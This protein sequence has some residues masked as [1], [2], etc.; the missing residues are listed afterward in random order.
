MSN[1]NNGGGFDFNQHTGGGNSESNLVSHDVRLWAYKPSWG[2]TLSIFQP[3]PE[4][5]NGQSMPM[6]H[7]GQADG[8]A[9]TNWIH[10]RSTVVDIG[11]E[12][13]QFLTTYDSTLTEGEKQK[14]SK[15]P[16]TFLYQQVKILVDSDPNGGNIKR[17][18]L[19]RVRNKTILATKPGATAGFMQGVLV[20]HKNKMLD[21]GPK[22]NILWRVSYGYLKTVGE[23]LAAK[24]ADGSFVIPDIFQAG[25]AIA[26][27]EQDAAGAWTLDRNPQGINPQWMFVDPTQAANACLKDPK[28]TAAGYGVSLVYPTTPAAFATQYP[29]EYQPWDKVFQ[30]LSIQEQMNLLCQA[31]DTEILGK[32]FCNSV[33]EDLLPTYVRNEYARGMAQGWNPNQAPAMPG[34]GGQ[35]QQPAQG[36]G[37]QQ[38]FGGGQQ[39]FPSQQPAYGHPGQQ[40]PQQPVYPGHAQAGQSFPGQMQAPQAPAGPQH[41]GYMPAPAM[42]GAPAHQGFGH[43]QQPQPVG[44]QGH[45]GQQPGAGFGH[46]G[47]SQG[48]VGQPAGGAAVPPLN[49]TRPGQGQQAPQGAPQGGFGFPNGVP[50]GAPTQGVPTSQANGVPA[51]YAFPADEIPF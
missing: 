10:A 20:C 34:Y 22:S 2:E 16:Y 32:V 11:S 23:L 33:Y 30:Q 19:D 1:G 47:P 25:V 42:G 9:Y 14:Y 26:S 17:R 49:M 51:G 40:V 21:K 15:D 29:H 6:R 8:M 45:G 44:H 43:G 31:L 3:R 13:T 35:P 4:V 37:G 7:P 28:Q 12:K 46:G 39:P 50:A 36:F 48:F 18:Y 24:K 27:K 41:P 5:A 38:G